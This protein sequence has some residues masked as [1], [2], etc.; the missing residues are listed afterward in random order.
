[1][2]T[3]RDEN[4]CANR[5]SSRKLPRP[6][7]Y[8]RLNLR[9]PP[10]RYS[11]L[12]WPS[13]LRSPQNEWLKHIERQ[14]SKQSIH[15]KITFLPTDDSHGMD[16]RGSKGRFSNSS[17]APRSLRVGFL[18]VSALKLAPSGLRRGTA[19]STS[20]ENHM[21]TAYGPN[22]RRHHDFFAERIAS[23]RRR[24]PVLELRNSHA[25]LISGSADQHELVRC[26]FTIRRVSMQI[27]YDVGRLHE[28]L[29]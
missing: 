9:T 10:I 11:G 6:G 20:T 4:I 14:E 5:G 21:V 16:G 12:K 3:D 7:S 13:A 28:L 1:V 23:G 27:H 22:R 24:E 26:Q 19:I 15:Q 29:V 25:W 8:E 18:A 2:I 17:A